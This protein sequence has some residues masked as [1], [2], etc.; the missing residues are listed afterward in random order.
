MERTSRDGKAQATGCWIRPL[1][2]LAIYLRDGLA[3]A[4]CG[5][6]VEDGAELSLDHLRCRSAGGSNTASNLVTAC[7]RCN[8][9]RHDRPWRA[10]AATVA[11]YRN[12]S[13]TVEQIIRR[14]ELT[15]RRALDLD[16]A[17]R[18]TARREAGKE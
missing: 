12:G 15:R 2:R 17:R 16:E 1:K 3:C 11:Q 4:Y 9:S 6:T 13:T 7:R 10:F 5:E 8:C 18:I 14:I